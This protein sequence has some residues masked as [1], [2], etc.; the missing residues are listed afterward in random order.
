MLGLCHCNIVILMQ[1]AI[2]CILLLYGCDAS[3][4]HDSMSVMSLSSVCSSSSVTTFHLLY[5]LC[6]VC[7]AT[8]AEFSFVCALYFA[9]IIPKL[10]SLGDGSRVLNFWHIFLDSRPLVLMIISWFACI[11]TIYLWKLWHTVKWVLASVDI[12]WEEHRMIFER[13]RIT[14]YFL[15]LILK[16]AQVVPLTWWNL[17]NGLCIEKL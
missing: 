11:Q 5:Y 17:L 7:P 2:L 4:R 13:S 3:I 16:A 8:R 1:F 15:M 6:V 14:K 10:G 9:A 12:L